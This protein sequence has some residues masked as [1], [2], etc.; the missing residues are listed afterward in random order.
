MART[1]FAVPSRKRRK[2]ILKQAKGFYGARSRNVKIASDAVDK[3]Q[4]HA[5]IGR[6][7]KKRQFRRLWTVRINAA[8]RARNINYSSFIHGLKLAQVDINR[9]MLS[10]IAIHDPDAFSKI[11]EKA[12][13]ALNK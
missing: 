11:V 5:F 2:K 9:K 7:Q 13:K 6:K 4:E 10:E 3:A 8:C 12:K 1:T